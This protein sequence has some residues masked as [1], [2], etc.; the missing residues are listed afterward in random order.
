MSQAADQLNEIYQICAKLFVQAKMI[1]DCPKDQYLKMQLSH[2]HYCSLS[3]QT[4][5]LHYDVNSGLQPVQVDQII[6][7]HSYSLAVHSSGRPPH[8]LTKECIGVITSAIHHDLQ[9]QAYGSGFSFGRLVSIQRLVLGL[10]RG[11]YGALHLLAAHPAQASMHRL[12]LASIIQQPQFLEK[13]TQ[14]FDTRETHFQKLYLKLKA[15]IGSLDEKHFHVP[16]EHADMLLYLDGVVR[17]FENMIESGNS[18]RLSNF[19]P[20]DARVF[21]DDYLV[22]SCAQIKPRK[23]LFM[24]RGYATRD[25]HAT[26]M[27]VYRHYTQKIQSRQQSFQTLCRALNFFFHFLLKAQSIL[28]N[29]LNYHSRDMIAELVEFAEYKI[30]NRTLAHTEKNQY[31]AIMYD[32]MPNHISRTI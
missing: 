2:F 4:K 18:N 27:D 31:K 17:I 11:I 26:I 8:Y 25:L 29:S 16:A 1:T 12:R 21:E 20:L 9:V 13:F 30:E 19:V 14:S 28:C 15:L 22:R 32:L 24:N 10:V 23:I 3:A 5:P 6:H 7:K